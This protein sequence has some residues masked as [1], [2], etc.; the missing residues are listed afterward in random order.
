MASKRA[1]SKDTVESITR[2]VV[3]QGSMSL[4]MYTD[5]HMFIEKDIKI[6]WKDINTIFLGSSEENLKD[7]QVHA[8]TLK[9]ELYKVSCRFPVFPCADV[10]H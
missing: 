2:D 3:E 10:I 5:T 7:Q 8:N 6:A 4:P 1:R 9:S